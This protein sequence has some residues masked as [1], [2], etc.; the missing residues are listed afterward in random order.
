MV[1]HFC[2]F[3]LVVVPFVEFLVI[4]GALLEGIGVGKKASHWRFF[5]SRICTSLLHIQSLSLVLDKRFLSFT[6]TSV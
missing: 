6:I 2:R 3:S 4:V 1:P 5:A